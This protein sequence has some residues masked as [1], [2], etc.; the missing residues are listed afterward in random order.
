M[1]LVLYFFLL[2]LGSDVA[3]AV[4]KLLGALPNAFGAS[5]LIYR[6][7][8]AAAIIGAVL[9]I[10][11]LAVREAGD[12]QITYLEIPLKELP[13][14][15]NGFSI[16]QVSDVHYGM[17]NRN[18]KLEFIADQVNRLAPDIVVITGDLVDG[19]VAHMEDMAIPL[20]KMK[21]R[22][23]VFAV[24]GNH[25][26]FAGVER[27]VG[28]MRMANIRVLRNEK[29]VLPGGIQ[30][31]GIDD[32]T[33]S[34]RMGEPNPDFEKLLS[35]LDPRM[36]SILLYHQPIQFEKT[37]AWGVGLQL[38]GHT[39]G[40]QLYPIIYIS[41]LIYPRT[42]GLHRLGESFLFVSRGA[43]TWGPPMRLGSPPELVH[44]R[45]TAGR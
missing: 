2:A 41:R 22:H 40:G 5:S 19:S 43:G 39:H 25:E 42:P 38:S 4:L 20:A 7:M 18:Q 8:W 44:I 17:L 11:L 45:L 33:G 27:A 23:G 32:P 29:V 13:A 14:G 34:R 31:L 9:G 15:G 30:L 36:P 3:A 6:R 21:G 26:Y 1:G 35:T 16:V 12:L 28:I 37:A 24:T 10:G